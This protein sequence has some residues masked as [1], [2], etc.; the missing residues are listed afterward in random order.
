MDSSHVILLQ[1]CIP[2]FLDN[3]DSIGGF[4]SRDTFAVLHSEFFG[5]P[6]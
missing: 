1:F 5:Q 6:T 3:L 2:N 4:K